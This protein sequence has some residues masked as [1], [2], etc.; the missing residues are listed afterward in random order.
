MNKACLIGR[1]CRDIEA[2]QT[3][4]GLSVID[5]ALAVNRR[6][7]GDG[8]DFITC[9]AFGKTADLIA[10]YVHKGDRLGVSGRIETG[11]YDNKDG[12]KVYTTK[13]I[14]DDVEFLGGKRT[15]DAQT[16][17]PAEFVEVD[18]GDDLPF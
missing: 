15:Q 6:K 7:Q 2:R 13:V 17:E 8:A 14:V 10:Q 1:V 4:T 18:D 11:V 3:Q 9:V 16:Q 12:I 5:F